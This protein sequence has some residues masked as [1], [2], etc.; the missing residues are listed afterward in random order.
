MEDK[1][2]PVIFIGLCQRKDLTASE[3]TK[4][5]ECIKERCEWY[6]HGCPAHPTE[7]VK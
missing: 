7:E 1:I 6:E 2:C 4:L 5:S 3:I